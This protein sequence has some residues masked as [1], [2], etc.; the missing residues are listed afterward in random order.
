MIGRPLA[1]GWRI[2]LGLAFVLLLV[3]FYSYLSYSRHQANPNDKT[4]PNARQ[5]YDGLK[6]VIAPDERSGEVMLWT[7]GW[8]TF[9]RLAAGVLVGVLLS[10]G[11]GMLMGCFTP[12]EAFFLPTLSF[13]AKIA[14]TAMLA[15]FFVLVGLNAQMYVTMIT[16]GMLPSLAQSVHAA[17]RKDVPEE[18]I[19]KAYTLGA[20]HL[21]VIWNVVFKQILPRVIDAVRLQIG[22]AMVLLVAAEWM[23]AGEGIGYQLRKFYQRT[24]MTVVNVYVIVLGIFGYVV[25][26]GLTWLRNKLCPWFGA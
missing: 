19:N 4:V 26:P 12:A 7:D 25:D 14:P 11:I 17:V 22:P 15:L 24:D 21:E 5:L 2:A 16:F 20:S 10:V 18:L 3:I 8:A 13:L 23:V 1:R 6:R 9:K